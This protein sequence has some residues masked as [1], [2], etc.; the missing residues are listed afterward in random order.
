[1]KKS[2][3]F[4][5]ALACVFLFLTNVQAAFTYHNNTIVRE[6]RAGETVSGSI[7][8]TLRNERSISKLSSTFGSGITL[9]QL[10]EENNLQQS[11]DYNCST[12]TCASA[13]NSS[14]VVSQL[15]MEEN[16]TIG[17]RIEGSSISELNK[18]SFKL[19]SSAPASCFPQLYVDSLNSG[20]VLLNTAHTSE[21]CSTKNNG[22]FNSGLDS[23]TNAL[24]SNQDPYCMNLTLPIAPAYLL[25]ARITNGSSNAPLTMQLRNISTG[26]LLGTCVLNTS[27]TNATQDLSCIVNYPSPTQQ[28]YLVCIIQEGGTTPSYLI[29]TETNSPVCGSDTGGASYSKDY[30]L[31]AQSLQFDEVSLVINNSI[32]EQVFGISLT[33]L[34]YDY[35]E[36]TYGSFDC[37]PYCII[38]F[39]LRGAE[40]DIQISDVSVLYKSGATQLSSSSMYSV[41]PQT[42]VISSGRIW[43]SLEPAAFKIPSGS[44]GT[45]T[46]DLYLQGNRVLPKLNFSI[47]SS[48]SI[49]LVPLSTLANTITDFTLTTNVNVTSVSWDFGD[50]TSGTSTGK[51]TTHTY[52]APGMYTLRATLSKTD[53][54]TVSQTFS[55]RVDNRVLSA[56][57]ELSLKQ[58]QLH[59]L[60]RE[61]NTYPV[62]I[63]QYLKEKIGIN[64]LN[65]SLQALWQQ[66][67]SSSSSELDI[68]AST[69]HNLEIPDALIKQKTGTLPLFVGVESGDPSLIETLSALEEPLS[70]DERAAIKGAISEWMRAHYDAPVTFEVISTIQDG[71]PT[72]LLTK[73]D[74]SLQRKGEESSASPYLIIS[75]PFEELTFDRSYGQTNIESES[76][77][78]TSILLGTETEIS[79]YIKDEF[80]VDSLGGYISPP[81][82]FLGDSVVLC[83]VEDKCLPPQRGRKATTLIVLVI[84]CAFIVYIILQEWYK[85]HYESHLFKQSTDLY[86]TINFIYNA[87]VSGLADEAIASKLKATAWTGE[88][89]VYAFKKIDG[90]RTG[91]YEIPLFKFLERRKVRYEIQ[92]RQQKSVD[93]RFIKRPS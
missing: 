23:Y 7:E 36:Q 33:D 89:V 50:G 28:N 68:L 15:D 1:M 78:G 8:L 83:T 90:K 41:S 67:N 91:M 18:I 55:I 77:S 87:R 12:A 45:R 17:I 39:A 85:R 70:N 51:R 2:V 54:T 74:I 76:S 38:P 44:N 3:V 59:N 53:G 13:Y 40:Q 71:K 24:V 48:S 37:Q 14:S 25:G 66:Y 35:L 9:L 72:P 26:D 92:R 57:E 16:A 80:S 43:L 73:F 30:E 22:C 42:P 62:W 58:Q 81:I 88:Q 47:L 46:F 29:R 86:N 27:M 69:A 56:L 4:A 32:F 6:Y 31:F 34:A 60:S 84:V 49:G 5:I 75:Y 20:N 79:F 93:V 82:G 52:Q 61:V 19:S 63:S 11:V 65:A 10:L 21:T 64:T